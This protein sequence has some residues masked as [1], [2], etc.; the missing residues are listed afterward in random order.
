MYVQ[1]EE[2]DI[3]IVTYARLKQITVLILKNQ[4][5]SSVSYTKSRYK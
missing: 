5:K 4:S 1:T 2:S 3:T